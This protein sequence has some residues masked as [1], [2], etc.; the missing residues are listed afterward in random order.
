MK[1]TELCISIERYANNYNLTQ[2]S[3]DYKLEL[4]NYG[5]FSVIN[6]A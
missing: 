1:H 4:I 6:R 3:D 2:H 5:I